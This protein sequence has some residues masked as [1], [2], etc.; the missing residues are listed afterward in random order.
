MSEQVRMIVDVG[1]RLFRDQV[2]QRL[3][4]GAESGSPATALWQAIV[5]AGFHE[6]GSANDTGYDELFALLQTAGEYAVPL[7]LAESLLANAW[8]GSETGISSIGYLNGEVVTG[9]PWG[10]VARRVMGITPNSREVVVFGNPVIGEER[11]NMAG[12]PRDTVKVS[13]GQPLTLPMDP[14]LLLCLARVVQMAGGLRTVLSMSI[15]YAMEREQFGRTISKFQAIQHSLAVMAAEVAAAQRAAA[16]AVLA[17]QGEE[18]VIDIAAAKAR[19]GEAVGIVAELAHQVHGAMGFTQ[20]HR[21]HHF[22]RR[23]WAARDEFGR[24]TE[25]Q[26]V[27]GRRIATVGADNMWGFITDRP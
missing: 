7:P 10:R 9:V 6:V 2:D 25:W 20:E 17:L 16:A 13:A 12:E 23:L 8:A 15:T 1:T 11:T 3:L 4:D 14:G 21:L 18:P 22:T 24:E 27:L 19:V 5:D 26:E